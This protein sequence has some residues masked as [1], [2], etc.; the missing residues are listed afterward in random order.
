[1]KP[2]TKRKPLA[3]FG[4][5]LSGVL[6]FLSWGLCVVRQPP[7]WWKAGRARQR[8]GSM[9]EAELLSHIAVLLQPEEP[10]EELFRDFRVDQ[11]EGWSRSIL[12]PDLTV[13]GALQAEEAA[14]F[15]EYDGYFRHLSPK[16][17]AADSRKNKALL[18]FDPNGSHV[19][20][21]A[22]AHRGMEL[23]CEMGEVVVDVWQ[24]GHEASLIKALRQVAMFLLSQQ[25]SA[26]QPDLRA[27]LHAFAE[28][29]GRR[30]MHAAVEFTERTVANHELEF[31]PVPL[32]ELLQS[33]LAL[34]P[35]QAEELFA[36]CPAL[37]R[38]RNEN[39]LQHTMQF[40][41]D[42]GLEKAQVAKVVVRYQPVLGCRIEENLKPT[43]RWLRDLRLSKADVAK[44]VARSP[45]VLGYSI[46]ENLKPT[47]QWLRDL[48]L[49]KADVA[50]VVARFPQTL[51]YSI[52]ENLK[53]TVQWLRDLGLSKADV[54]K[55]IA[56]F[57]QVLGYSIEENL[58]PTVQW[59]RDLGLSK[60]D[61]TKVV[62]R[63][64]QALGY[65][66][67]E[68]L[69]PTV[70]WLGDLRLSKTEVAK[71][72][73]RSPQVLG[74]SIEE[75]LKPTVR[76]IRDLGLSKAEVAKVVLRSPPILGCGIEENLKPTV[77]W[78]RDLGLS[79]AEVTKVIVRFP[80]VLGYSIKENLKPTVRW[81]RDV[82]LSKADVAKVVARFPQALGYSIEENLKPTVRWFR[83]LRLSKAEVAKVV[84]RLPQVLG[85]SIEEN[86]KVQ[87]VF[88]LTRGEKGSKILPYVWKLGMLP[89]AK[90]GK[91][92]SPEVWR[93]RQEMEKRKREKSLSKKKEPDEDE[94]KEPQ[95]VPDDWAKFAGP[96][97]IDL[98]S[99]VG[100][101]SLSD[102]AACVIQQTFY[103]LQQAMGCAKTLVA[104]IVNT[105]GWL[106]GRDTSH[107]AEAPLRG[108]LPAAAL[109]T[110]APSPPDVP[111]ILASVYA[112]A[113]ENAT[114]R[115]PPPPR[116]RITGTADRGFGRG[117]L[118]DN[119]VETAGTVNI[120]APAGLGSLL[121]DGCSRRPSE[122][123]RDPTGRTGWRTLTCP[124]L[125]LA[126]LSCDLC[127]VRSPR[128]WW[129]A[130]R[131]RQRM[132]SAAEAELLSHIAVLLQPEEPIEELFRD[133]RVAQSEGWSRNT[134]SPDLTVYGALQAEEAALFLE[135]DGYYRHLSPKGIAAD[136]RKN[137]A[138]LDFAPNGSHVLRIAHAHRGM[139]L[140]CEMG[141]V[142]VDVWQLGHEASL[143]N[144]LRQVAMFLLSQ[145]GN[146]LQPDLRAKLHAFAE[147]PGRSGMHAAV[148]FTERTVANRELEFDPAPLHESLQS[149]LSLS[150]S[151]AEELVVKLI[152]CPALSRRRI[153][154]Q[155]QPAMQFLEDLGLENA[156]VAKAIARFPAVLGY[157]IEENLKPTVRWLRDLGLSKAEV[158]KVIAR[159]PQVLGCSIEENLK[160]TVRWL[161]DVGLSKVE[162]AKVIARSPPLGCSIKEN[163]KPT[164]AKVIARK[165]Q[166]LG[167]S[168]EE[169]LKPTVAKVI[170]RSPP[171]GCSIKENLKPTV[172]KVIARKPQVLGCSIEENLKPTVRWFRDL[173]LSKAE[174]AKVIARFP[175]VVRCCIED[176]LKPTVQWLQASGLTRAE[177]AKVIAR[178]A[179][180]L[181]VSIEDNLETTTQW[182][183][184]LG[185]TKDQVA[186]VI[187]LFPQ[188]L[189]CRIERYDLL[190]RRAKIL[191]QCS[192]LSAFGSAMM[193]TDDKFAKR[194][195]SH[196][197]ALMVGNTPCVKLSDRICP[198]GRTIY[199]KLEYFNPLGSVK[200]RLACAIIEQAERDGTLKPG[201]TVIEATSGNT[202]IGLAML[203]AQRGY[204]CVI[205]MAEPFSVER[206]KLMRFLGAKVIITPK[207]GKGLGMVK[208]AQELAE[209]HGWFLAR[210]FEAK[211]NAQFHYD[212]TGHEILNDFEGHR[213]DYYVQG[214]G[215][216]GTFA[217]AGRALREYE[218]CCNP[219]TPDR[220]RESDSTLPLCGF[221]FGSVDHLPAFLPE[222]TLQLP[223][224]PMRLRQGI[225]DEDLLCDSGR[226]C[227]LR[228]F[229]V[230]DLETTLLWSTALAVYLDLQPGLQGSAIDLGAGVGLT[231]MVLMRK[232]LDVSCTDVDNL[233]LEAASRN[234][235]VLVEDT[236]GRAWGYGS[237]TV[238]RFNY[239]T[240][241]LTWRQQGIFPPYDVLV[242]ASAPQGE[243][244]KRLG[245]FA[246]LFRRLGKQGTRVFLEDQGHRKATR[247][248]PEDRQAVEAFAEEGLHLM[249]MFDPF[250]RGL[251]PLPRGRIYSLRLEKRPEV[252]ICLAEPADAAMVASGIKTERKADGSAAS[253]HP[254]FKPHPIQ[255]WSPDF[256]A[257]VAEDGIQAVGYEEHVTIPGA[258]AIQMAHDL[259]KKEGIFTGISGGASIYAAVEMAKRAPEGSVL[260]AVIADTG[261]RYLSTPLFSSV[262][263]DMDEV[264]SFSASAVEDPDSLEEQVISKSTPSYQLS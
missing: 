7:A 224:G 33:Q 128:S 108:P 35:S 97:S 215:T 264:R 146:A 139:E 225:T 31:D 51:G 68:N 127:A 43:V 197:N 175:Q 160:P 206:R 176:N 47:V 158:A 217:G 141:E 69:K 96:R 112:T 9:A 153:D 222:L 220:C 15:L 36:E 24:L 185:L 125:G 4:Y 186:R 219:L 221:P 138:L 182:L 144:A 163:L 170:A 237:L 132:G 82:G 53:P 10:I 159:S 89:I 88:H 238:L 121:F 76:W 107:R 6:A 46:E 188:V 105:A 134:L 136:S 212:T 120:P 210:Q 93:L 72:I 165:P 71:V 226:G 209:T 232:G 17:I 230:H 148:E 231:C 110:A 155:L 161:R 202:G 67:E 261:E 189:G 162:V 143:I 8:I 187:A 166:V 246:R 49:S 156:Q 12:S 20:R 65:S 205:T 169:N 23:S 164:V 183:R 194:P 86:L 3:F 58:K 129:K 83:D 203:C 70:R 101:E 145:Q 19:L 174:V 30:G 177:V 91:Y 251:W 173:G 151:E 57:P 179:S 262:S 64:P 66:I 79:K 117:R 29:P 73:S 130:G 258:G 124:F 22:H 184:D 26:L 255:G 103:A 11:S 198:A 140:S 190:V 149:R 218:A 54:A 167:C 92:V 116:P 248:A 196:R 85:F 147:T 263:V 95:G 90:D 16:G 181:C 40:L 84:A 191:R 152:N 260:L 25:G 252:K 195:S 244:K 44:V 37:S 211:A 119:I 28:T 5:V 87:L 48:G 228:P 243:L 204:R 2:P 99:K 157:S 201:D 61:V 126:F 257:E 253:T 223:S 13:Y 52:E 114:P 247:A 213:L 229:F 32:R 131:A 94:P 42:L 109:A 81:L 172:A 242:M 233:A 249:D 59:L 115:G 1:M 55:V 214:F 34:S 241:H 200:D 111:A 208:K 250:D 254:A 98:F 245:D 18:D 207:S 75:N 168:I 142:V 39:K 239:S 122:G 63:F 235:Q 236:G 123:M 150:L 77:Q 74:C 256:I 14:L 27:R 135:Y 199:A 100:M 41:E 234:T 80:A 60:A 38:C 178:F 180:V 50:K 62:A 118:Y 193:L 45:Q 227:R 216:G 113:A 78:L 154:Q 259:A 240:D 106:R 171:L 21:I 192:K 137:K 133:F 104:E 102:A 56:R